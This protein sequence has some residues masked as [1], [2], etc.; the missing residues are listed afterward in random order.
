[1]HTLT[2]PISGMSCGG[3]VRAVRTAL[4]A[5]QGVQVDAVT[6]GSATITYDQTRITGEAI[7]KAIESAGYQ[8]LSSGVPLK[9][10]VQDPVRCGCGAHHAAS[11]GHQPAP[12]RPPRKAGKSD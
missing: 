4:E 10:L 11:R 5:V 12:A 1:M 9:P 8:P 2:I 3:C 6:V 7:I